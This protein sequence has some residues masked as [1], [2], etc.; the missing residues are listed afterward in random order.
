VDRIEVD[1][2]GNH[3]IIDFKTGKKVR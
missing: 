2:A 1:S 3:Y